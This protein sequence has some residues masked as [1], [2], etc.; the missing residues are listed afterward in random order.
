MTWVN[1]ISEVLTM[2]CADLSEFMAITISY[3]R[4]CIFL[5]VREI[6]LKF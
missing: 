2:L 3:K 4:T 6:T 5:C 1:T